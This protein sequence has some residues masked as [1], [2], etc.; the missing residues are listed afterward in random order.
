MLTSVIASTVIA[1]GAAVAS[2]PGIARAAAAAGGGHWNPVFSTTFN[3]RAGSLPRFDGWTYA[4]G[5]GSSFGN[6]QVETNTKSPR[7]VSLDGRGHLDITARESNGSWTSGRLQTTSPSIGAPA[8]GELEVTASIR[9]PD[10]ANGTGY[11]PAFWLRGSGQWP[12]SGEIDIMESVNAQSQTGG[13]VDCGTDPGGPCNEPSGIGGGLI[14]CTTCQTAY[15]TYSMLLNRTNT[16]DESITFYVDGRYYFSV[17][18]NR[19]GASAWQQAFDH[20][21]SVILDLA[22]GGDYPNDLCHCTSPTSSTS[23]GGTLSVAY[24]AAYASRG[25]VPGLAPTPK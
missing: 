11:W 20:P 23:S 7:N 22:I 2:A 6:N 13:A 8:G 3:G 19:V 18:E 9:Q 10:P 17:N 4:Q 24:V 16:S 21:L 1:T 5:P 12:Q 25:P 15:H 14:P